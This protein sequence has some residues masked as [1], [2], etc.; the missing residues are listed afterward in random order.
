VHGEVAE[1]GVVKDAG[2]DP[3]VTHGAVVF[4]AIVL[5]ASHGVRF[6]AGEGVGVVTRAGLPVAVGEPAINPVPQRMMTEHLQAVAGALGY[7]GGFEATIGVEGG[8]ELALKTMNPRL[9]IEGGLS[10][11]G[12]T[13]IVK[14]FSCAAYIASI[15]Q[16]ID[17]ARANGLRHI[18]ACTGSTSEAAM[19]VHLDLPDM[20]LVEMGDF[21]G[22]VLKYLRR[23]PVAR[24][25]LAGGLG[26]ISKLAVG[27][28]DLHS[29]KS[30]MDFEQLAGWAV[31][32]GADDALARAVRAANTSSEAHCLCQAQ[33]VALA[34]RVCSEALR[35][36][37]NR[38]GVAVELEVWAVD[39][40]G[41][42]VGYAGPA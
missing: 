10:I 2:D 21:V 38:V 30:S 29:G 28:M 7:T 22:A 16:G 37:R 19:R 39:R 24:V 17:V 35:V 27:H 31:E 12:T 15:H 42:L 18:A 25:S 20:A 6:R 33:A 23:A 8:R 1:A 3:D 11:L 4:A 36:A 13:G 5:A 9:G 40:Q 26:K 14:P 32:S 41:N 34:D